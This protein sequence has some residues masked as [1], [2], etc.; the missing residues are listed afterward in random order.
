MRVLVLANKNAGSI[1]SQAIGR[2][3][4]RLALADWH[5]DL[6]VSKTKE[7]AC[8]HIGNAIAANYDALIAYGGDGTVRQAAKQLAGTNCA[9]GIV[10]GGTGN[11]IAYSL[12]LPLDVEAAVRRLIKGR[13]QQV[14]VGVARGSQGLTDRFI[15]VGGAGFDAKLVANVAQ[16]PPHLKGI[17]AYVFAAAR[18]IPTMRLQTVRVEA[19]GRLMSEKALVVAAANGSCYGK[20]L[21]IAPKA[22]VSDGLLDVCVVDEVSLI[23]LASIVP[24]VFFGHHVGH[25]KVRYGKAS[26]VR[27]TAPAPVLAQADGDVVGE[28]PVEFSLEPSSLWVIR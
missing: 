1:K 8:L 24:L 10:P 22:N 25:P 26:L 3:A 5:V 27:V 18:A 21:Y 11:G 20:G 7:E 13:R 17:P 12:G 4:S 15:N 23:E 9:L 14:D 19:D 2:I 28:T 6:A 16:A